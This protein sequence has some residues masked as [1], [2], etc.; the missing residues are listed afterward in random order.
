MKKIVEYILKKMSA[1]ALKKYQPKI[2]GV[3]G[4]MGK[5]ST[6]E[7]IFAVLSYKFKA[8]RNE[9]NYNN[10]IGVPLTILGIP[11]AGR[12]PIKWLVNFLKSL[13]LILLK[14]DYPEVLILEMGAD[15]PGDIKYLTNFIK[16]D[17]GVI[18]GIGE[19]PV[20]IEFFHSVEQV[21]REKAR[22][23]ES[24]DENGLAVLNFDDE[25][26]KALA[27]KTRAK[28][29]SYGFAEDAK[30]RAINFD[31]NIGADPLMSGAA[32]KIEYDGKIIPIRKEGV[33]G[34]HQLYPM[35]AAIAVG[36]QMGL[37]L[38]EAIEGL[39]KY[40]TPKGRL[41]MI[42]GIKHSY[43]LDDTYNASPASTLAALETLAKFEGRRKI[44]V[45]GDM[46]ELGEF[47]E[48][49]HRQVGA[50]AGEIA[51]IFLAV[52]NRMIFAADEARKKGMAAQNVFEF[53]TADEARLPLQ[54]M[55]QKGDVIL[56]KGSQGMR[57]EKVVEEIM[58]EP[59][60][61]GE[62]LVRQEKEWKRK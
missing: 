32:F 6:K 16:C 41:R 5:T 42:A 33:L 56:I 3:T 59:E 46:L 52:G 38:I 57:L 26:V 20:H 14:A 19:I 12:S 21:V 40:Q 22:L 44:A 4:S 1:A 61:A 35:L 31:L 50:K 18:T 2:I 47:S 25:K 30:L 23:I 17:I 13:K 49:A 55:I 45:L 51:D 53:N 36:S 15:K 7:A 37:N 24:L 60:K 11:S 9:K 34:H 48:E 39:K 28:I 54:A 58:A 43:V 27:G 8:R 62:L 29:L 10:E